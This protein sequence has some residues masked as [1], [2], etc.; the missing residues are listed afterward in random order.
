VIDTNCVPVENMD[1]LDN[2]TSILL[3]PQYSNESRTNILLYMAAEEE[4]LR[5]NSR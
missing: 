5:D 3:L 1:R 2:L 4:Y